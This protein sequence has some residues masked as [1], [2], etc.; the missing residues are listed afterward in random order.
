M[1]E[2]EFYSTLD[3]INV[4]NYCVMTLLLATIILVAFAHAKIATILFAT[5]SFFV[6]N[7]FACGC[8]CVCFCNR[9]FCTMKPLD[10]AIWDAFYVVFLDRSVIKHRRPIK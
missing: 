6:V 9:E 8:V 10:Y 3:Q 5:L 7:L 1:T 2:D 4:S